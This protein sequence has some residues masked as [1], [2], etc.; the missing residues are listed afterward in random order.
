MAQEY[1]D[2]LRIQDAQQ[3]YEGAL[4]KFPNNVNVLDPLAELLFS[5]GEVERAMTVHF[6]R[7]V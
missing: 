2:A 1:M 3:I 4:L 5:L 6:L 7:S